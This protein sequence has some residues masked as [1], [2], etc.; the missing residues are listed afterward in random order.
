MLNVWAFAPTDR[1]VVAPDRGSTIRREDLV[2][3]KTHWEGVYERTPP[4]ASSWYQPEPT[5]SLE[6][7]TDLGVGPASRIIDVGGGDSTLA[8]AVVAR[9][10]GHVTVLDLSSTALRRARTRLGAHAAEVTWMESDVLQARLP[11]HSY[12]VWHDRAVFHFLTDRGDRARYVAA[13]TSALEPG[14]AVVIATFALDGPERCSGLR[15]ARYDSE[16]L[17]REFGD[18]FALVKAVHDVH[19]TPSGAEQQFTYVVLRL[20]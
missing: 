11:S 15:V 4:K 18:A 9:R 1:F 8:D 5:R 17:A 16:L 14:G 3:L 20:R 10:L 6:L 12:D 19:R 13:A 2:D 7:L